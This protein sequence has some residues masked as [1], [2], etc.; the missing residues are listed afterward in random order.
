MLEPV[1]DGGFSFP[2]TASATV[3]DLENRALEERG[4][5]AWLGLP[6][7]GGGGIKHGLKS[8]CGSSGICHEGFQQHHLV[9]GDSAVDDDSGVE[10]ALEGAD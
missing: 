7:D 4:L 6:D 1:A 3:E 8:H 2:T 9:V 5:G 10:I